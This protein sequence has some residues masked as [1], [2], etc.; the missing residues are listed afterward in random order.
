MAT[1][2]AGQS[3]LCERGARRAGLLQRGAGDE[4]QQPH[5]TL[6]AAVAV[7]SMLMTSVAIAIAAAAAATAAARTVPAASVCRAH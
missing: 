7:G 1:T 5:A 6:P 2:A 4:R 3:P